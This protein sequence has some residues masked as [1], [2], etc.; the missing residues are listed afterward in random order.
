M[1]SPFTFNAPTLM[2]NLPYF[3]NS[4]P[5]TAAALHESLV[6]N[7]DAMDIDFEGEVTLEMDEIE[8]TSSTMAMDVTL[9]TPAQTDCVMSDCV[10]P[11][12]YTKRGQRRWR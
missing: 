11:T 2:F 12:G 8:Y 10:N 4:L 6:R 3:T 5:F 1:T 9:T 7:S